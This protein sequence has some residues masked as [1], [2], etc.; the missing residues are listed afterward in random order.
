M[1][2]LSVNRPS[3]SVTFST[4]DNKLKDSADKRRTRG[5]GTGGMFCRTW[6]AWSQS[7][8][9]RQAASSQPPSP[10]R[11]ESLRANERTRFGVPEKGKRRVLGQVLYGSCFSVLLLS[12][13]SKLAVKSLR[14]NSSRKAFSKAF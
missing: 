10:F 3:S 12:D 9:R 2:C 11:W 14:R 13:A 8:A 1:V 6:E 4:G 5:K 7:Q